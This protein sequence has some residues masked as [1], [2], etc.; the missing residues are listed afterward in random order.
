MKFKLSK[1]TWVVSGHAPTLNKPLFW[2]KVQSKKQRKLKETLVSKKWSN[3]GR[4]MKKKKKNQRQ[5]GDGRWLVKWR[6]YQ[7]S[8]SDSR[9][10]GIVFFFFFTVGL[11]FTGRFSFSGRYPVFFPKRPVRPDI[12][13]GTKQPY[14][15]SDLSTGTENSGRYNTESTFLIKTNSQPRKK[16]KKKK[17]ETSISN[18]F[19]LNHPH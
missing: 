11:H 13:S 1:F 8:G 3:S 10:L 16:K 17:R 18:E 2:W 19:I 12:W 5:K 9:D 4:K 14:F 15:C 7:K 6:R